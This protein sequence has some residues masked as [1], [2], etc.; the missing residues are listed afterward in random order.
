MLL[1]FI[2]H[3]LSFTLQPL[4]FNLELFGRSYEPGNSRLRH[5]PG[6]PL[7]RKTV[8]WMKRRCG[9]WFSSSFAR[10]SISLFPAAPP[11]KP[12]RSSTANI[13]A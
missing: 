7:S 3:P 1:Y 10:E 13:S 11:A 9:G 4:P 6:H 12:P 5:G 2:L 8:P